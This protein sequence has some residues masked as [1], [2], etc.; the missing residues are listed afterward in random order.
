MQKDEPIDQ[1]VTLLKQKIKSYEYIATIQDDM[2][3]DKLVLGIKDVSMKERLL[4]EE[5][6][7]L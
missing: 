5:S 3:H 4:R 6:L 1:F 7:T 2:V